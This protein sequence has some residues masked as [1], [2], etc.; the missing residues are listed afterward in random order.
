MN[1]E[2]MLKPALIGGIL[3][4]VLS[5]LPLLNCFCC[6][7]TIAGGVLAAYLY[8]KESP[9]VVTL[10]RG[11][12]LGLFTGLIGTVVGALFWIPMR[13]MMHRAGFVE[14]IRNTIGQMPNVPPETKQALESLLA[15]GGID[16]VMFVLAFLSML[17]FYCIMA[18]LGGAMGVALFEKRKPGLPAGAGYQ[19][20]IDVPPPPSSPPP[21]AQ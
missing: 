13:L 19:G 18:M 16:T 11:V 5:S 21:D 12:G 1:E 10:G 4:G 20:P 7:W 17:V 6:A 14:Q 15:R 3:L 9:V 2:G 8:V